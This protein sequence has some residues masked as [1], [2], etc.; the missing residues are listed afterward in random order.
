M[1]GHLS[2][3]TTTATEQR[4]GGPWSITL[5][6]EI[7][8]LIRDAGTAADIDDR[9]HLLRTEISS[10]GLV[11]SQATLELGAAEASWTAG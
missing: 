11:S 3:K 2:N 10:A 1:A 9:A 5:T 7:A 4:A 8:A 6:T